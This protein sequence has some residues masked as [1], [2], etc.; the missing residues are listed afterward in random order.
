MGRKNFDPSD[1]WLLQK[2]EAGRAALTGGRA[3]DRKWR[4]FTLRN[5]V[6][7]LHSPFWWPRVGSTLP[8]THR[9]PASGWHSRAAGLPQTRP[10]SPRWP[11]CR[12]GPAMNLRRRRREFGLR[13]DRLYLR[14]RLVTEPFAGLLGCS[15]LLVHLSLFLLNCLCWVH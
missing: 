4:L 10:R 11:N 8:Q 13:L 1:A 15:S 3:G 9:R 5:H 12:S 2:E 6:A 14:A 7:W